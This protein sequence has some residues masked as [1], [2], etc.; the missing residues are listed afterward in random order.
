M[1]PGPVR[2]SQGYGRTPKADGENAV[3]V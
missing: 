3:R 2:R 1:L